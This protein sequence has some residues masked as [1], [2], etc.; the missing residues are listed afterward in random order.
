[1][2]KK[3]F[4]GSKRESREGSQAW[5][6]ISFITTWLKNDSLVMNQLTHEKQLEQVGW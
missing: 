6:D 1:M 2:K 5:D 4:G 3:L